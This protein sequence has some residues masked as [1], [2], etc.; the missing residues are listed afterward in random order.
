MFPQISDQCENHFFKTRKWM[1]QDNCL[2]A[3]L[4]LS[5]LL[6]LATQ[7]KMEKYSEKLILWFQGTELKGTLPL[8]QCEV[9][10]EGGKWSELG[11]K[12]NSTMVTKLK[13]LT[14]N[15]VIIS[16]IMFVLTHISNLKDLSLQQKDIHS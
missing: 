6:G 15:S 10:R 8:C 11:G 12:I 16:N 13:R 7:T 3:K 14:K 9:V 1:V 4:L 5:F 2:T